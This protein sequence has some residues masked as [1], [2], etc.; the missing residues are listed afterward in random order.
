MAFQRKRSKA[1][2][3]AGLELRQGKRGRL[4]TQDIIISQ[5][6]ELE[7][8]SSC[9]ESHWRILGRRVIGSELCVGKIILAALWSMDVGGGRGLSGNRETS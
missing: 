8:Y 4:G 2:G 6:Y 9:R 1:S 5:G 3:I 7:G